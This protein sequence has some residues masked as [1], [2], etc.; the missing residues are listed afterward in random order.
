MTFFRR[1]EAHTAWRMPQHLQAVHSLDSVN[2]MKPF[3]VMKNDVSTGHRLVAIE[4]HFNLPSPSSAFHGLR[5]SLFR[6]HSHLLKVFL[7]LYYTHLVCTEVKVFGVI[8]CPF[9]SNRLHIFASI[10]HLY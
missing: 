1:Q 10:Y 3:V 8:H 2:C 7:C 6:L 9:Y 4:P 5:S